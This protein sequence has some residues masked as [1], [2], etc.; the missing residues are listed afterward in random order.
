MY[1][2]GDYIGGGVQRQFDSG[3]ARI[4]V[5]GSAADVHISVAGGTFADAYDLNFAGPPG[6]VL[7]SGGVDTDA[8]RAPF[9][10]HGHPDIDNRGSGRG[11]NRNAGLFEVKDIAV[12]AAGAISRLW[13]VY[14]QHC[15]G[16]IPALWGE[17]KLGQPVSGAP[18]V[19][20]GDRSLAGERR[21]RSGN[22][23]G[24]GEGAHRAGSG[25]G[26]DR[27]RI[28]RSRLPDPLERMRREEPPSR[29]LLPGV[30]SLR[31]HDRRYAAGEPSDRDR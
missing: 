7:V 1:S 9:R 31:P 20:P 6:E 24:D 30:D 5:E 25:H 22:R 27:Q 4:E 26:R 3:N 21:R 10:E 29:R 28:D 16:G 23:P 17:V 19:A 11:C 12:D 15:E 18:L 13:I 14:E 8:Q 2:D